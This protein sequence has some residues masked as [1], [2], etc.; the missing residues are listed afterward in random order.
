MKEMS[1]I[2]A[3]PAYSDAASKALARK[4]QLFINGEWVDS[5]GG[6]TLPVI[7]PSSGREVGRFVDA[8]DADV[9]RAV[10]AARIAFD[11]GRW[12]NLP[13]IAREMLMHKLADQ[14][15]RNANELAELE[16]I[17]NGKPK[18]FAAGVDIPGAAGMLRYMAGWATK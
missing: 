9:D 18:S 16:A 5:T 15:E 4:P 7:D 3:Q 2:S 14:I 6:K 17:D 1:R 11:D 12:S 13:P 10:A 8:T